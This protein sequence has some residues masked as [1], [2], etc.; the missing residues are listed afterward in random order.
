VFRARL[1]ESAF[2]SARQNLFW[3]T[4]STPRLPEHRQNA[5]T[6][7]SRFVE[8]IPHIPAHPAN[9]GG[10]ALMRP[11]PGAEVLLK[12]WSATKKLGLNFLRAGTMA[13]FWA[14]PFLDLA[15]LGPSAE[16]AVRPLCF[17]G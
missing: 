7:L 9:R 2:F 4:T 14:R 10:A 12:L 8:P 6:A 13:N 5:H 16:N 3:L 1:T 15:T 11:V 17:G